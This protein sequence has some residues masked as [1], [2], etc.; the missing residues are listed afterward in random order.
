MTS[1]E[2]RV[3]P[4][5][6]IPT[7]ADTWNDLLSLI[8]V[9]RSTMPANGTGLAP[10]GPW[11]VRLVV[12]AWRDPAKESVIA[13][14][15]PVVLRFHDSGLVPITTAD[16]QPDNRDPSPKGIIVPALSPTDDDVGTSDDVAA[17]A[18]GIALT[19]IEPGRSGSVAIAGQVLAWVDVTDTAHQFAR[20]ESTE[21]DNLVSD[22]GGPCRIL[23]ADGT[24]RQ[25]CL[26]LLNVGSG[27]GGT[28][29]LVGF[30]HVVNIYDESDPPEL[31]G[32]KVRSAHTVGSLAVE[33]AEP[34]EW[35]N[36]YEGS[37]RSGELV[38]FYPGTPKQ[39][40][41]PPETEED[42]PPCTHIAPIYRN[43]L[44]PDGRVFIVFDG[45]PSSDSVT[46]LTDVSAT[47]DG[48]EI[49]LTR[50]FKTDTTTVAGTTS[51]EIDRS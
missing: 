45:A 50:T 28:I 16:T 31:I 22:T 38:F 30:G 36:V 26:L 23:Y 46:Q 41:D 11:N 14:R 9:P 40:D 42:T 2:Q 48:G 25:L 4:G 6:P 3:R 39:R 20:L 15:S 8:D 32:W 37:L 33:D 34:T 24:G 21:A 49:V 51:V 12:E 35:T 17:A 29:S 27:G 18:V 10:A 19:T 47:C 7:R 44:D 5:D 43:S 13:S 1:G